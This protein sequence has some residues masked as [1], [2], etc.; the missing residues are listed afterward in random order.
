MFM[1]FYCEPLIGQIK[2]NGIASM[3]SI[4]VYCITK[5]FYW[6]TIL[7]YNLVYKMGDRKA[8]GYVSQQLCFLIFHPA[9]F[10]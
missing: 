3:L 7:L 9:I 6:Y 10:Y 1:V 5:Q 2:R 4:N 8:T